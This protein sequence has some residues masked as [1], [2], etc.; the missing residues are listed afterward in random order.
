MQPTVVQAFLAAM[1]AIS[2]AANAFARDSGQ[3][4]GQDPK[5]KEWFEHLKQP[6]HPRVSC[7]GDADAYEAD[8]FEVEGDHYVAIITGHRAVTA[9][10]LGSRIPVPR[11]KMKYDA[12]NPTGHGIIF[13]DAQ[14][15]VLCY[16]TPAAG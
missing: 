6:D 9:I 13:I 8:N 5:I 12:G 2:I 14:R 3:W 15:R 4:E 11:Q 16:V 7:C 1:W 10:P